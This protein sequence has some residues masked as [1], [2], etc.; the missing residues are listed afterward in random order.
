M[1]HVCP[2]FQLILKKTQLRDS[3]HFTLYSK[4]LSPFLFSHRILGTN[5]LAFYPS[6]MVY[7]HNF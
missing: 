5:G 1:I 7:S 2:L 4:L 3:M 6:F